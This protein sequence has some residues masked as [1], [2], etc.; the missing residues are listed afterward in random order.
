L[1]EGIDQNEL[2]NEETKPLTVELSD[3]EPEPE[4]A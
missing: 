4:I 1:L 3:E 2:I